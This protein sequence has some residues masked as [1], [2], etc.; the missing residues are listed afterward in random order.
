MNVNSKSLD[1]CVS[2]TIPTEVSKPAVGPGESWNNG[3]K[4]EKIKEKREMETGRV[5]GEGMKGR[6]MREQ[7]K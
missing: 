4:M 5:W 6:A 3:R 7:E 1:T 2:F